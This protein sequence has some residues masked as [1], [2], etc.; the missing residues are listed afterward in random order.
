MVAQLLIENPKQLEKR[1]SK[2]GFIF[3]RSRGSHR[4]YTCE[5]GCHTTTIAF[6]PG[7]MPRSDI[8]SVIRQTGCTKDQ[9][10]SAQKQCIKKK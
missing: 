1:I 9:F 3:V 4:Q 6:H 2:L 8:Q 10:Y 5:L 7:D